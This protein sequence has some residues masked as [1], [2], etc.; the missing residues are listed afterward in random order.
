MLVRQICATS[1]TGSRQA[2]CKFRE[3]IRSEV[4]IT[5]HHVH[6]P[7]TTEL[8]QDIW[9][10]ARLNVPLRPGIAQIVPLRVLVTPVP[11]HHPD[12]P[13][14]DLRG[15]PRRLVHDSFL[16]KISVSG[17]LGAV[18]SIDPPRHALV[19]A[20]CNEIADFIEE[21]T[22]RTIAIDITPSPLGETADH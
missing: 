6:R 15:I 3:V 20:F 4:R 18:H 17:N 1:P 21:M 11:E 7:P 12:R 22:M 14:S 10:R 16:S 2:L 9:Q 13:L 8:L 5:F 19:L